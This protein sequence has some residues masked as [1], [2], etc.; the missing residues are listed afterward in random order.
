MGSRAAIGPV[1]E[2]VAAE[3]RAQRARREMTIDDLASRAELSRSA[4]AAALKGRQ[5]IAMEAFVALCRALDVDGARLVAEAVKAEEAATQPAPEEAPTPP[6]EE[7]PLSMQE[8]KQQR[9][10]EAAMPVDIVA[11]DRTWAGDD[12][13]DWEPC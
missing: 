13:D 12:A 6:R 10:I 1:T 7:R 5:A 3:L 8:I 9:L 2:Y 4:V 11:D